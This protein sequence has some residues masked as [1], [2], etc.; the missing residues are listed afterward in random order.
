MFLGL[1]SEYIDFQNQ[2]SKFSENYFSTRAKQSPKLE[3]LWQ[4]IRYSFDS[5]GKKFRPFL[6]YLIS[7]TYNIDL[8]KVFSIA[9]AC[10][11]IHTYSLIHDDL[12]CMDNDDL[13]RGIPTNHKK[14]G[15]DI[16][17]LAGD[18][19]QA[20]AFKCISSDLKNSA[21]QK[22]KVID[23]F[24]DCV[25]AHGMVGG[26]VLDMKANINT[27]LVE[28]ENIHQLKTGDLITATVMG[29]AIFCDVSQDDLNHLKT[30]SIHLGLAFQIKDDLLDG[31]DGQ[32]DHKSYLKILGSEKTEQILKLRSDLANKALLALS[33][34]SEILKKLVIFNQ[35]R[36]K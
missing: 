22:I 9:L 21:E 14:F 28:L 2:F 36:S 35:S 34:N 25:G 1:E 32:Q 15:E 18:A 31:L 30:F 33:V 11:M 7:K 27:T 16:A 26:Q 12:P 13:R 17:L 20:E 6:S 24:S 5:G 23:I 8:E 3:L 29:A 19:L 4:S 10:E